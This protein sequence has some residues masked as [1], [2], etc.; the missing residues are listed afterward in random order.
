MIKQL[1]REIRQQPEHIRLI[2]MWTFVVI[3]FS[4]VG[5]A[6]FQSTSKEYLALLNPDQAQDTRALAAKDDKK[7]PSPFATILSSFGDLKANIS[8]LFVGKS[9]SVDVGDAQDIQ[10]PEVPAQT[11]PLSADK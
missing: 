5:F 3:T 9:A 11:F 6:W 8:D 4:V 7:T 10:Q 1:V 2:F